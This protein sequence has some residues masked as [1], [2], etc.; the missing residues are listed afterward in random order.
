MPNAS[1]PDFDAQRFAALV[2]RFDI[3]NPSEAEAMNA[4]RT[5]RRGL[6][7]KN[8]RFVDAMARAD[9]TQALDALLKPDREDSAELK[10]AFLEITKYADMAREHAE[11]ATKLRRELVA[12][13]TT[14]AMRGLV[15]GRFV[16]L[17]L[18]LVVGL[19]IAAQWH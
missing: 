5:I 7:E 12:C 19:M 13:R 4:A 11:I 15:N 3:G 17:V 16:L 10:A 18:L 14:R 1:I 6:Q 9:V 2:A 8:V